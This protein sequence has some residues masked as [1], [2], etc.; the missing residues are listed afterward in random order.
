MKKTVRETKEK[1]IVRIPGWILVT[2]SL[3]IPPVGAILVGVDKMGEKKE[4]QKR[5]E[6][7]KRLD[8]LIESSKVRKEEKEET[9]PE[10]NEEE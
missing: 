10:E 7:N 8:E 2:T 1:K 3:V 6:D 9:P 4:A 5:E